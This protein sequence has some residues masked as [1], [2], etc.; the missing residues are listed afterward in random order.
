[1]A[2]VSAYYLVGPVIGMVLLAITGT[3]AVNRA[4][5]L[6]NENHGL[7][8]R[9]TEQ[10]REYSRASERDRNNRIEMLDITG[11]N[12]LPIAIADADAVVAFIDRVPNENDILDQEDT[13]FIWMTRDGRTF[14]PGS[15]NGDWQET[16]MTDGRHG[17]NR[18]T[19]FTAADIFITAAIHRQPGC[20][21]LIEQIGAAD[22]STPEGSAVMAQAIQQLH[23]FIAESMDAASNSTQWVSINTNTMA[24]M[25]LTRPAQPVAPPHTLD[26][27]DAPRPIILDDPLD[28]ESQPS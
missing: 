25:G 26:D 6:Q 7:R 16:L 1:M 13:P 27:G 23:P 28:N 4:V 9:I 3:R 20:R 5:D 17:V 18:L 12:R 10:A 2:D 15:E 19:A 24:S 14:K 21:A 11:G 22:G 8:E